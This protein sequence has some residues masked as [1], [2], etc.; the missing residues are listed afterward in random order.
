MTELL[1]KM[2][3]AL[4]VRDKRPLT[5]EAYLRCV[6]KFA[7]HYAGR[8]L[9]ELGP[10]EVEA[11]LLYLASERRLSAQSRNVYASALRFLYAVVLKRPDVA[12][13][14]PKARVSRRLPV[15]LDQDEVARLVSALDSPLHRT[16]AMLCYGAGLRISE[17]VSLR[18]CDIDSQRGVLRIV[19]GKGGKE[20]EV[21]LCPKLLT[22]LRSWWQQ[23]RPAGEHLFPGNGGRDHVATRTC[24]MAMHAARIRAGLHKRVSPHALRH[25]YATHMIEAGADLRTVQLLLGHTSIRSTVIYVHVSPAGLA[26][27][28][29]PLERLPA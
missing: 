9:G 16:I 10:D 3:A 14:I 17:A 6:R 12:G 5:R 25:S 20:R 7:E 1:N 21:P 27:I 18:A 23:R 4:E 26:R 2:M 22:A 8:D 19:D 15:V 13:T 28:Q 11:F 29:S 24:A